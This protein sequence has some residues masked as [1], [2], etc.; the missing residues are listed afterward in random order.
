[1]LICQESEI[2][3]VVDLRRINAKKP[4]N[5]TLT[6]LE[7]LLVSIAKHLD[8]KVKQAA[9]LLTNGSKY[10]AHVIAKGVKGNYDPIISWY[11]DLNA[12]T[13]HI[14]QLLKSGDSASVFPFL[15]NSFKPGFV[16]KN[17]EVTLW[18][19]RLFSKLGF[20]FN[21]LSKLQAVAW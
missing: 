14:I 15:M 19:C 8:L 5:K 20:E 6:S 12:N 10:L 4:L 7:F 9:A 17:L 1:L 13:D 2:N 11:Q 21:M 18:T 3:E 16:S